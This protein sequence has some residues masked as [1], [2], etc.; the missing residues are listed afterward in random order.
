MI[1]LNIFHAID[2]LFTKGL[3]LP[4]KALRFSGSWWGSNAIN[5]VFVVV[6]LVYFAY[7]MKESKKFKDTDTEDLPK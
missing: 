1:A 4:F 5:F 7:W 2:D 6:A 3:F